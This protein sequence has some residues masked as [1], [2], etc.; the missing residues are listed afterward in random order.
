MNSHSMVAFIVLVSCMAWVVHAWITSGRG[1]GDVMKKLKESLG[2]DFDD[3]GDLAG[4]SRKTVDKIA[5][6][7]KRV[8]VLERIVT[9]RKYELNRELDELHGS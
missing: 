2:G 1:S 9:D 6:L 7:E 4:A 3:F 5:A 8:E